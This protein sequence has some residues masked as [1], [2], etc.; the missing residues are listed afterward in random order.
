MKFRYVNSQP[1]VTDLDY[2]VARADIR[3]ADS[4]VRCV[5]YGPTVADAENVLLSSLG[6]ADI[7]DLG[8]V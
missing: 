7:R 2:H 1:P 3:E 6:D 5:A 4:I 8:S